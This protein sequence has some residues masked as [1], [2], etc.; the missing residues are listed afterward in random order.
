MITMQEYINNINISKTSTSLKKDVGANDIIQNEKL[1]EDKFEK[2]EN[3][4]IDKK[5]I[6]K[7]GAILTGVIVAITAFLKRKQI[8]NFVSNFSKKKEKLPQKRP[9]IKPSE[10]KIKPNKVEC[11]INDF[12]TPKFTSD[13]TLDQ[14]N[15]YVNELLKYM[16]ST[17]DTKLQL[18]ALG[19][20]E[21][22]GISDIDYI[23][24][25]LSN[26]D[27]VLI[28]KTLK[29]Y[30]KYGK[31]KD[32]Y[33]VIEPIVGD[34]KIKEDETFIEVLKT[35]QKLAHLENDDP[36]DREVI[37][38]PIRRLLNHQSESVRKM[39]QETLDKL[40]S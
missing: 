25:W 27:E 34:I 31:D 4:K 13:P 10:V 11:I 22:Y 6:I 21:K 9:E 16:N 1:K 8:I 39:A 32:A 28:R 12:P 3:K 40:T 26:T 38:K 7:I 20:I 29:I 17:P 36:K 2:S 30:Q 19:E 24:D 5:K 15:E 35:I 33:I 14:K 37:L 18:K 23:T